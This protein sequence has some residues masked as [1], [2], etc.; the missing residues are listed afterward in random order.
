MNAEIIAVGTEILLGDIV[1]TNAQFIAKQLANL[2]ISVFFQTVVGD[3][4]ARLL[5]AY[6]LAF[7][8]A[9]LVV[10]TGGLGPTKDDLTKE[11]AAKFFGKPLVRHTQTLHDIQAYFSTQKLEIT[12][13]NKKQSDIIEGATVL[14]NENGTAPGILLEQDGKIL[15]MLP[16][17]PREMHPMFENHVLPFLKT[18]TNQVFISKTLRLCGIGES[19][20]EDILKPILEKQSNPT[21][22]PYA[23]TCEVH[24]RVTARAG[25]EAT[26]RRLIKPVSDQIYSLLGEYIYG[27]DETTL[28]AA[29]VGMLQKRGMTIACA[30]SCTGGML[31]ARLVNCPGASSVLREGIIAY[32]NA[33]KISRL[34]VKSDTLAQ[35]GAV[36]SQTAAEMAL[37]AAKTAGADVGVGIT[38]IAGPD[39]GT[40]EKPVGLVYVAVSILG[41][42]STVAL[43]IVGDRERVRTRSVVE[44]L[45]LIRCSIHP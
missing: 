12:E 41:R 16:G 17:P 27:E 31:T 9:D 39:G 32:S 25:D 15:I 44:A 5:S 33:S 7:E 45:N 34:G 29:V 24:F 26:A 11:T 8:R 3:N 19:R 18:K 23:K 1:N 43:H 21:I 6:K 20:A 36:S 28:E 10:A 2:G 42:V 30:E 22:A 37:G 13:N 40:D 38:G 4:E 14:T 35:Y